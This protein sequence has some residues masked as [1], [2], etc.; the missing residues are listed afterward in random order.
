MDLL[1]ES[2][3]MTDWLNAVRQDFHQHPETGFEEFRTQ[4]KIIDFLN[5]EGIECSPLA[6]TGVIGLIRGGR[7]GR[8]VALRADIDA[9]RGVRDAKNTPYR[10][11]NDDA[12]HC[13]GH[14]GHTA[15]Q[16]GAARLLNRHRADM[17]GNVKLLFDPAE[18]GCG[19]GARSMVAEGAL[20]NPK[21]DA[22]FALH[23][24]GAPSGHVT[25]KPGPAMAASASLDIATRRP[26]GAESIHVQ[27][28]DEETNP[29]YA[30]GRVMAEVGRIQT[31][32]RK[33]PHASLVAIG[34][35]QG[36]VARNTTDAVSIQGT[37]RTPSNAKLEELKQ[38]LPPLIK[39]AAGSTKC[40]IEISFT[41][42]YPALENDPD[43]CQHF[44]RAAAKILPTEAIRQRSKGLLAY[45][46][47]S[48]AFFARE[49]PGFYYGL[50]GAIGT[51][52]APDY[53]LRPDAL[54]YGVALQAQ[55]ALDF[56]E[57]A[58]TP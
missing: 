10:S 57:R 42:G 24:G 11:Q 3:A 16:M 50:G 20:E 33:E 40:E 36:G 21:V 26:D 31:E 43:L 41:D 37:L 44:L 46:A 35:A 13:C 28:V 51:P 2:M 4:T 18:E 15:I 17:N 54:P 55:A 23:M 9:V 14:D 8:T 32:F 22:V 29:L 12:T 53:D 48:F 30:A 27:C 38:L 49:T 25:V 6:S 58:E 5:D 56:L 39:Q 1:R 47:D 52:H 34:F 19:G 45:G 7:P